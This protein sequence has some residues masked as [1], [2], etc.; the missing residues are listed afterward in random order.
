MKTFL[1]LVVCVVSWVASSAEDYMQEY[2]YSSEDYLEDYDFSINEDTSEEEEHNRTRR[3][4]PLSD[5]HR[6]W[7]NYTDSDGNFIIP[8]VVEGNYTDDE[9][10]LLFEEMDKIGNNTCVKFRELEDEED[11]IE[12]LNEEGKG[13]SSFVGRP[14]GRSTILLESSKLRSCF[15]SRSIMHFLLSTVGLHKEHLREDRDKYIRVHTENILAGYQHIFSTITPD[16]APTYNVPYDYLSIMHYGKDAYAK[17]GTVTI[18]TVDPKYQEQIG[19]QDEPSE[20]DYK[21]VCLMYNCETCMGKEMT[22]AQR[23]EG[24]SMEYLNTTDIPGMLE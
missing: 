11:Y 6:T 21:K 20:N 23:E 19:M 14:G 8:Y 15:T 10:D 7:D 16:N 17:P 4:A 9:L 12:I 2:D 1:L 22:T 18:E 24:R 5:F 13:C 3:N